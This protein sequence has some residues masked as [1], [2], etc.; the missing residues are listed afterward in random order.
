M[1]AKAPFSITKHTRFGRARLGRLK[2]SHGTVNTPAYVIVATRG[3]VKTLEPSDLNKTRTQI[4][5]AN[6]YHLWDKSGVHKKLGVNMPMMTDSGGFQVFSL[7]AAKEHNVGKVLKQ[8]VRKE[9]GISNVRITERGVHFKVDGEKRFLSPEISMAI[10]ERLGADIIFAFDECTSPLH[11]HDYTK[12]SMERTHRW[13]LR[14]A[15][16]HK[17]KGQML[18]GIVQGGRFR[19]LRTASAKTIANMDFDGFGIGGSFG[20]DEMVATLTAVVPH[21]PEDKPRHLLGIGTVTDIF[22]AVESGIDTFDCVIPTREARHARLYT[23]K[24]V[25]DI[26]KSKFANDKRKLLVSGVSFGKLHSLFRA[27]DLKTNLPAETQRARAGR[28]ATMHNVRWFNGLLERIRT[29]L[30]DGSYHKFKLDFLSDFT[31]TS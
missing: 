16:A 23:D 6:T 1:P 22:A 2:T 27:R 20:K 21:L 17:G 12:I 8:P 18:Y 14:C 24:G 13:A 29:A 7:G 10:Q 9:S 15:K 31:Q 28:L 4:V 3:E 19:R 5:I 26:R 25:V 11:P 30:S